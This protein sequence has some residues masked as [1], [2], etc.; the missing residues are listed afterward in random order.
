MP[1]A[2]AAAVACLI[3]GT[4]VAAGVQASA[5]EPTNIP[6]QGLGP[7]L[8]TL[9]N[10]R[11]VH[12]VFVSEDV[13]NQRTSGAAGNLGLDEALQKL[14]SG[15]GL[16]YQ[17]IDEST[18]SI[19]PIAVATTTSLS[20]QHPATGSSATLLRVAIGEGDVWSRFRMA[21]AEVGGGVPASASANA[22]AEGVQGENLEEV[23]VTAQKREEHLQDVPVPVSVVNTDSLASSN[24]MRLEDYY[25][26]VP[27][28]NLA[29]DLYG[30]PQ[31]FIR[32]LATG[33]GVNPTVSVTVDDVP[34]GSSSPIASG[35]AVPDLDPGDLARIEVLRG[36]QGTLYG[37][38]SLGGLLKFVT[39]DPLTSGASGSVQA[40]TSSI[41]NG[42]GLGY[43]LRASATVPLSDTF[44]LRASGFTRSDPGFIDNVLTGERGVNSRDARGGLLSTLWRPSDALS[45]KFT[46]LLQKSTADGTSLVYKQ[47]GLGDLEQG[48]ARGSGESSNTSQV[49]GATVNA[50]LGAV[51]LT[52]VTGYSVFKFSRRADFSSVLGPIS[53][54]GVPDSGFTGFGVSGSPVVSNS[55]N[56]RFTQ[57]LRLSIP[58]GEKAEWLLGA[59]YSDEDCS[60]CTSDILAT[61]PATGEVVGTFAHF[62]YRVTYE[63]LAAFTNLTWHFTDRFDVQIGGRQSR[64]RQTYTEVDSGP[65]V[66]VLYGIPSPFVY[67]EVQTEADA[68]TYLVTPRFKVSPDLM[69]Y[70]RLASGYRAGGPNLSFGPGSSPPPYDPDK[71]HNYEI[72]VKGDV[73][74]HA[75]SFD[76][77]LYYIE[78]KDIQLSVLDPVTFFSYT[79]NGGRATSKGLEL[80]AQSRPLAGLTIAAWVAWNDAKLT[81]TPPAFAVTGEPGDRLPYAPRF[82]GSLSLDQRFDLTSIITGFI[83]GSVSYVGNREGNFAS[84]F[85]DSPERPNFPAYTKVD[86]RGGAEYDSWTF[87][88]FVNNVTDKRGVLSGGAD[89]V[90]TNAFY[91]IQPRTIGMSV[92]KAFD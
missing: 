90:P 1:T 86:L 40:G 38:N 31:V 45:L 25:T 61:V 12:L 27:A 52:S 56:E 21:R 29:P 43:S 4:T 39:L 92:T 74:N 71:T 87:N 85:A 41:N 11:G 48:A 73:F 34:Y 58:F 44:A 67:P 7:A 30:A 84:V 47:A 78:W 32:G 65:Y 35:W 9:S 72:G 57:E 24:Q 83:G 79:A 6:A 50:K 46:A 5:R 60:P 49:Y 15:T 10:D 77:S 33:S 62:D 53:Q 2:V 36:P 89:L 54:D 8:R 42:D 76:T 66:P 13:E 91:Y 51:D 19:L 64:V 63:D 18:V 23:V 70:A 28:V 16:T 22:V 68:F 69:M 80:S 55:T 75:L 3:A 81:E 88:I 17:Y 26:K 59:F 82:S 20:P 14:L 37:A